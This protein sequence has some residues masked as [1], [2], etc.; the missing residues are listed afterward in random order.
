MKILAVEH[1]LGKARVAFEEAARWIADSANDGR[2][3][4]Q[5]ERRGDRVQLR[6]AGSGGDDTAVPTSIVA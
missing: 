6:C 5:A 1:E 3:A 2:R 4:D